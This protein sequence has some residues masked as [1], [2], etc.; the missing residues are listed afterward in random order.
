MAVQFTIRGRNLHG[1]VR[2]KVREK[3]GRLDREM[4][5]VGRSIVRGYRRRTRSRRL[6]RAV[7]LEKDAYGHY[8]V[9]VP[10][11]WAVFE[12]EDTRAHLIT[13]KKK[14]VLRFDSGGQ[15]VFTRVVRHPGTRGSHALRESVRA[16]R[17]VARGRIRTVLTE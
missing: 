14:K 9:I 6:A 1:R 12:E 4:R 13:P 17:R 11:R 7:R 5:S 10:A 8:R 16:N 3:R 15:R 2:E